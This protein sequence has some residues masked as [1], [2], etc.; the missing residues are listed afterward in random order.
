MEREYGISLEE[1][2]E[3]IYKRRSSLG[4]GERKMAERKA[5]EERGESKPPKVR[6]KKS[7]RIVGVLRKEDVRSPAEKLKG[8]RKRETPRVKVSH[9]TPRPRVRRAA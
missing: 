6:V 9:K 2:E 7:A 4:V 1:A 3:T 5:R 8:L